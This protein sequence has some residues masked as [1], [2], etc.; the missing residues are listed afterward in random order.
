MRRARKTWV[1]IVRQYERSGLT[2]A[3]F[4]D[5]LGIPVNTLR[6]WICRLRREG[7]GQDSP[8]ILPVRVIA[9]TAPSAR[10]PGEE[11]AGAIEVELGEDLRLHFPVGTPPSAIA[12]LVSLLRRC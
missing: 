6:P 4:A 10:G 1:G 2:Q 12:E 3:A 7:R 5:R 8:P 9:S 11:R